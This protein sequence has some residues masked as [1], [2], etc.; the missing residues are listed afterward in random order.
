MKLIRHLGWYWGFV[1]FI[2]LEGMAASEPA[3]IAIQ[4]HEGKIAELYIAMLDRDIQEALKFLDAATGVLPLPSDPA[5]PLL[6]ADGRLPSPRTAELAGAMA[7]AYS[8]PSSKY[9]QNAL[10]FTAI[11]TITRNYWQAAGG[12]PGRIPV[13]GKPLEGAALAAHLEP[14]LFAYARAGQAFKETDR[15]KYKAWLQRALEALLLQSP[16]TPSTDAMAWCGTLALGSQVLGNKEKKYSEAAGRVFEWLQPM[17]G[18]GGE[19][20]EG[21]NLDLVQAARFIRSLFLFRLIR[22]DPALDGPL[23]ACLE[24]FTRL[25][26][27]RAVPLIGMERYPLVRL[28]ANVATLLG[29]LAYYSVSQPY[30]AQ[31]ATRYLE[32]LIDLPAGFTLDGGGYTFLLGAQYHERPADLK[33]IPYPPYVQICALKDQ[34][35]YVLAGKNYQTAVYLKGPSSIKG[36]QAWTYQGG[37]PLIFPTRRS[38]SGIAGIG[39]DSRRVDAEPGTDGALY[40]HCHVGSGVDAVLVPYGEEAAAYLFTENETIVIFRQPAGAAQA[41]WIQNPDVCAPADQVETTGIN[42][43]GTGAR[44]FFPAS[45]PDLAMVD[46]AVRLRVPFKNE[47]AWFIFAGSGAAPIIRPVHSGLVFVH[48]EEGKRAQNLLVNLSPEPFAQRVHFPGTTVPVPAMDAWSVKV[49][50][51]P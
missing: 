46:G 18:P 41:D 20:W 34:A 32:A 28:R 29:P 37:P 43:K 42:F 8:L 13:L 10:V 48:L 4:P 9:Y 22:N 44:L 1:F 40:H 12:N 35:L 51:T 30:F 3:G 5:N 49:V 24:W 27:Y 33:E 39:F 25:Y 45:L 36:I 19:I 23:T 50:K 16:R 15:A 14:L 31:T 2:A 6:P 26:S 38:A 47:L 21:G 11:E 17:I 7:F